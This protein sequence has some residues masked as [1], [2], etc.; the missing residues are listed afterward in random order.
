MAYSYTISFMKSD[1]RLSVD[2]QPHHLGHEVVDVT[3]RLHLGRLD[4]PVF[5]LEALHA[6]HAETESLMKRWVDFHDD[7]EGDPF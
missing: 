1:T 5:E 6:I 7:D 3:L 2:Y 4:R